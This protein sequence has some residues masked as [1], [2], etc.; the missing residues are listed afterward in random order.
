M[1]LFATAPK[2]RANG[3]LEETTKD[4]QKKFLQF[5]SHSSFRSALD[6][7]P[8][9]GATP[10]DPRLGFFHCAPKGGTIHLAMR[11]VLNRAY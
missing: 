8:E 3:C 11:Q 2:G 5:L 9:G 4:E 10:L 6:C 1:H 7:P